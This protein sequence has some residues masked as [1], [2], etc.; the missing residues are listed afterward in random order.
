MDISTE[1]KPSIIARLHQGSKHDNDMMQ[2]YRESFSRANIMEITTFE[3]ERPSALVCSGLDG[4][5]RRLD[6]LAALQS[7][8]LELIDIGSDQAIPIFSIGSQ[9][10]GKENTPL[11]LSPRLNQNRAWLETEST[12]ETWRGVLKPGKR[13]AL[14]FSKN[15]GELWGYYSDEHTGSPQQV[16]TS[17][18]L[19]VVR[20]SDVVQFTV[21]DDPAPPKL[22]ATLDVEPKYCHLSGN[23][24]FKISITYVSRNDQTITI[25]K[26]RSPL[27]TFEFDFNCVGQLVDCE[28]VVTGEKVDWPAQFGCFDF[29]PH[30]DF[31]EDADFIE[32]APNELWRFQHTLLEADDGN[33]G[34]L[35]ELQ[36]GKT[37]RMKIAPNIMWFSAWLYGR[38]EELLGGSLE[39][40]RKRWKVDVR[41]GKI[42]V[43]QMNEPTIFQVVK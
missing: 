34:G 6:I 15:D 12:S 19:P 11:E 40:K 9:V 39:E 24:A 37:Y 32:L 3:N 14:R 42:E 7:R 16:P 8:L 36:A 4:R 20:Q 35:E 10:L 17:K 43:E 2:L 21:Y 22:F 29:D 38:K 1:I 25:N 28:D 27:S 30:P 31:P 41:Q 13:Y 18:R 26:A 5:S 33:V 23:L